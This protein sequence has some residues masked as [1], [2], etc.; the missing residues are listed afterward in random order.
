MAQTAIPSIHTSGNS[1][2][3]HTPTSFTV[4]PA[5]LTPVTRENRSRIRTITFSTAT[6]PG[7]LQAYASAEDS[8]TY[9][10]AKPDRLRAALDNEAR[11][12]NAIFML[13]QGA[14]ALNALDCLNA[15]EEDNLE[16]ART[17]IAGMAYE[18]YRQAEKG[19][20]A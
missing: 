1:A 15:G 20:V 4:E 7:L 14:K 10:I 8:L 12:D 16:Y 3:A 18:L 5:T 9:F 2:E 13:E 19:G 17:I 6:L 11:R